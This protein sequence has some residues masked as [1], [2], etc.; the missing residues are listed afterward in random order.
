MTSTVAAAVDGAANPGTPSGMSVRRPKTTG[1]TVAGMSMF[2]VPTMVGVRN[3][4][5]SERRADMASGSRDDT[6]TRTA[7]TPGP[8]SVRAVTQIPMKAAAGPV[9]R[10]YPA[11]IRP[12]R[13][14]CNIVAAPLTATVQ[15]T[16]QDK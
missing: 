2:T 6:M 16:A 11:P 15:N 8:P 1:S 3:R 12:I 7:N 14:A 13:E 4:R 10:M 9:V 5:N